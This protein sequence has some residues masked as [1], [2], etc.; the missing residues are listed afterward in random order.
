MSLRDGLIVLV[1]LALAAIAFFVPSGFRSEPEWVA[2]THPPGRT[3]FDLQY[4]QIEAAGTLDDPRAETILDRALEK[5]GDGEYVDEEAAMHALR[6]LAG[7][8]R[9]DLLPEVKAALAQWEDDWDLKRWAADAASRIPGE[10]AERFLMSLVLDEDEDVRAAAALGLAERKGP[11]VRDSIKGLLDDEDEVVA[12][13]A[14]GLLFRF[15]DPD[16]VPAIVAV[17]DEDDEDLD[18]ALA[19]GLGHP[20]L[21]RAL[22]WLDRLL[23]RDWEEPRIAAAAALGRIGGAAAFGRL[24]RMLN[25]EDESVRLAAACALLPHH[26]DARATTMVRKGV[27]EELDPD[28]RLLALR[29]LVDRKDEANGAVFRRVLDDDRPDE[30][31]RIMRVWAATGLLR[32]RRR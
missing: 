32:L 28:L 23:T 17:L 11:G 10:E 15:G 14:A 4:A 29:T 24:T 8:G 16:A 12:A 13:L 25:D 22:P 5:D 31:V 26:G 9:S 21:E 2:L 6:A 18:A 19:A 1:L 27:F 30:P 3:E 7:R 20:G